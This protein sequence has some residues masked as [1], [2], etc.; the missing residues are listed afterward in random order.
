MKLNV[1]CGM[2]PIPYYLNTDFGV[3]AIVDVRSDALHLPFRGETFTEVALIHC[4]EHFTW[5]DGQAVLAEARRVLHPGGV[6]AVVV[7]DFREVMKAWLGRT[8][9]MMEYPMGVANRLNNL[10]AINDIFIYSYTQE[11]LHKYCYDEELLG[12]AITTAGY[13]ILGP[14]DRYLDHRLGTGQFFQVGVEA[15]KL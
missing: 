6:V 14:I 10:K 12:I 3:E 8:T 13:E 5:D 9:T 2:H 15:Q 1:G 4:L 7:P 11:S